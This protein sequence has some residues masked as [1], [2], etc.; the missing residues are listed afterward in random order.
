MLKSLGDISSIPSKMK[1]LLRALNTRR[2]GGGRIRQTVIFTRFFD[3]LQDIVAR[4]RAIDPSMLIGTYSGRGG[5]YVDPQSKA[6]R[7]TERDEIK[8]RFL[9]G[10][11]DVL[12]CTDAAAEGLNLQI[13]DLLINYDLPWNPMKVEQ[14]IGRIDRIG[15]KYEKIYVLNL[16]YVDS[17]EQV[18]YD[19]LLKRLVHA[20][21]VVGTQQPSL[22]PVTLDEFCALADG[23]LRID[24]IEVRAKERIIANRRR[25]DSMEIGAKDLYEIYIRM[26]NHNTGGLAPITLDAIWEALAASKYLRDLGC[27]VSSNSADKVI[28]LR[29]FDSIP[30]GTQLTVNRDIFE[31]GLPYSAGRS[32]PLHFA[33]YGDT[34]FESLLEELW[35]YALPKCVVRLSEPVADLQTEIIAYAAAAVDKDGH[36]KRRLLTSWDDL[37]GLVLDESAE[38][39]SGELESLRQEFRRLVR[40]EFDPM[41]AVKRIEREN[42]RVGIAG[43][44]WNFLVARSLLKRIGSSDDDNFWA[45][46]KDIDS[47]LDD[48][49]QMQ[50]TDLP[51]EILRAIHGDLMPDIHVPQTGETISVTVPIAFARAG[52]DA[53]C[54][55][56]DAMKA[57][58]SELSLGM[59]QARIERELKEQLKLWKSTW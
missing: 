20:G 59:V 37:G 19:R 10:D 12:V 17:A 24:E 29:G 56:A 48:R 36:Q 42:R 53:G 27:T 57:R 40:N 4:L 58:K 7:G 45:A 5:Q 54:R 22:L 33:S 14:R 32:W 34:V 26:K 2:Q 38:I 13:A 35:C 16:C 28:A 8:H 31:T 44:I 21:I 46:V 25:T 15:Q 1:E 9:R 47:I 18:V 50:L 55:V 51:V 6:L 49:Y 41:Q 11:I 39:E 52:V 3:T 23:S 43:A 30:S